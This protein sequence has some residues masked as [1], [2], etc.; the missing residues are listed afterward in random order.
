MLLAQNR[1]AGVSHLLATALRNGAGL[2]TIG[3][4]L[5][6]AISGTYSPRASWSDREYDIAFLV[7]AIGGPRLLYASP[8]N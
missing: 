8:R 1:I 7:K 3:A 2:E 5:Q 4:R 6:D